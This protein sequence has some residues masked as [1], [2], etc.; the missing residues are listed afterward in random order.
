MYTGLHV[1]ILMKLNFLDGFSKDIQTSNF[2]KIRL[3]GAELFPRG[4]TD[5]QKDMTKLIVAFRNFTNALKTLL[6]LDHKNRLTVVME[7]MAVQES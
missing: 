2:M 6:R 4:W 5:R 1:K 3:V 7:F